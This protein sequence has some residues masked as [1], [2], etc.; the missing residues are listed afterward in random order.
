MLEWAFNR[1]T[2]GINRVVTVVSEGFSQPLTLL[3][4]RAS[5]MSSKVQICSCCPESR[6]NRCHLNV[7]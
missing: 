5:K 3:N 4:R 6:S 1:L 2:V 7:C